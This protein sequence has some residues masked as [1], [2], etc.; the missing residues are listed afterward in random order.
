MTS[1]PGKNDNSH[2]SPSFA[3]VRCN[4]KMFQFLHGNSSTLDHMN[5]HSFRCKF[6]HSLSS[7]YIILGL[8]WAPLGRNLSNGWSHLRSVWNRLCLSLLH[9]TQPGKSHLWIDIGWSSWREK[10]F[11]LFR[12]LW[13][14]IKSFHSSEFPLRVLGCS[15]FEYQSW[16]RLKCLVCFTKSVQWKSWKTTWVNDKR[17]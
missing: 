12:I 14:E 6:C 11:F 13:L 17:R 9:A 3:S 8:G 2:N 16:R 10:S 1:F 15:P 7:K 4:C 5:G